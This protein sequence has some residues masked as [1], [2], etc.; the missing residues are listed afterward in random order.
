[1]EWPEAERLLQAL[2]PPGRSALL[3]ALTASDEQ[4]AQLIGRLY[5]RRLDPDVVELLILVEE[6]EWARQAMIELLDHYASGGD[7]S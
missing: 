5:K 6:R 2:G 7:P 4:R 1:V 3:R